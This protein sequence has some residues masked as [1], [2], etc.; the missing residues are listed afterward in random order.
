M[1]LPFGGSFTTEERLIS[2]MGGKAGNPV[3]H[4]SWCDGFVLPLA[5]PI[6]EAQ[7]GQNGYHVAAAGV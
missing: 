4:G 1:C 6:H 3:V 5:L 7:T 2:H